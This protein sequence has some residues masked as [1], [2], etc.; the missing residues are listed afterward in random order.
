MHGTGV[1]ENNQADAYKREVGK[2]VWEFGVE[3]AWLLAVT[4]SSL[5]LTYADVC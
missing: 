2:D 3:A 1:T 5:I 4:R